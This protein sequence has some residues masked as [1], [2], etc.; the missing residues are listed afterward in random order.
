MLATRIQDLENQLSYYFN[1]KKNGIDGNFSSSLVTNE[2]DTSLNES[3]EHQLLVPL[4]PHTIGNSHNDAK[5]LP[6]PNLLINLSN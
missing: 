5:E 4:K 1:S 2:V 3:L 6:D